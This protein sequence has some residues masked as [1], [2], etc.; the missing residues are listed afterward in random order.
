[1]GVGLP[2]G[3]DL[4]GR[5]LKL[6]KVVHEHIHEALAIAVD[7]DATVAVLD[8]MSPSGRRAVVPPL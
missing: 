6:L 8:R 5:L 4:H 1:V 2:V 7:A 3:P